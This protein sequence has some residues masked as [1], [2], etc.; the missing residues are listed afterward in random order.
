M[1]AIVRGFLLIIASGLLFAC[2]DND[3]VV[4]GYIE[5]EYTYVASNQ[6]G[7]LTHLAVQRGQSIQANTLIFELETNPEKDQVAQAAAELASA[8]ATLSDMKLGSR[9]EEI[10]EILADIALT[11][12]AIDFY[13]KQ[14]Q[15]YKNLADQSYG[16]V[17]DYDEKQFRYQAALAKKANYQAGLALAKQGD[18]VEQ[19]AAQADVVE[20][21]QTKLDEAQWR[22]QQKQQKAPVSGVV[23]DTYYVQGEWVAQ[24][25]AV[26]SILAPENVQVVFF[27]SEP[28]LP[29]IAVGNT[30]SI[31]C[32]QC[33]PAKA[34][35]N[36]ISNENEYTP[37]V[38]FSED[39]RDKLVYEVKATLPKDVALH[40]HPGQPIDVVLSG[41]NP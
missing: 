15:R 8:K 31:Q 3:S 10:D 4:Q 28:T 22:L 13:G 19:I 16:T 32:D 1:N 35:I 11:D 40:Y 14:I 34:T 21:A 25:Q 24:G 23:F 20:Q 6:S 27:V 36:Y 5:G 37:P 41:N 30:V 2:S 18:R 38:I 26:A 29:K 9:Q 12:S 17:E 33:Q 39:M 7:H